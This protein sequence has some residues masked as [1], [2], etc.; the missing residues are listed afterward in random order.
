ML[1]KGDSMLV[2]EKE[3]LEEVLEENIRDKVG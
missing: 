1:E 3:D 2:A